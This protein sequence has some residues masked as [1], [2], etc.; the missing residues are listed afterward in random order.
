MTYLNAKKSGNTTWADKVETKK[1]LWATPGAYLEKSTLLVL[2]RNISGFELP[3][4]LYE[5]MT[6]SDD[7]GE[8]NEMEVCVRVR[9]ALIETG[10]QRVA[11]GEEEDEEEED[12]R[13]IE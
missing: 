3:P 13:E 9:Q 2:G 1:I 7:G 10:K 4:P 6:F 5:G 12:Y 8:R 11:E